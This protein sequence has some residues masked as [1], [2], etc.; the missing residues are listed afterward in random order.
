MTNSSRKLE[1][2][3]KI[4]QE[5]DLFVNLRDALVYLKD[6]LIDDDATNVI[7]IENWI[8]QLPEDDK[9]NILA[10]YEYYLLNVEMLGNKSTSSTKPGEQ[11]QSLKEIIENATVAA[12]KPLK[13]KKDTPSS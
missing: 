2:F 4:I 7:I 5:S 6:Q 8:E 1:I 13:P 11:S 10:E 9:E 3:E 12:E